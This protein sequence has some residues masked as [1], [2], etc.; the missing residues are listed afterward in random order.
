MAHKVA[1]FGV[2]L[3]FKLG[4]IGGETGSILKR[5]CAKATCATSFLG[6]V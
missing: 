2:L 4:E 3:M 6:L 1:P 5:E